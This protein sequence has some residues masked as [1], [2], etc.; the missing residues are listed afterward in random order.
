MVWTLNIHTTEQNVHKKGLLQSTIQQH[1]SWTLT[2]DVLN[3]D[4]RRKRSAQRGRALTQSCNEFVAEVINY[5]VQLGHGKPRGRGGTLDTGDGDDR[6][7]EKSKP[8]KTPQ[9]FRQN[10]K[11]S[12]DQKLTPKKFILNFST[13]IFRL[14]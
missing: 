6:M 3:N 8:S 7:G 4:F 14:F 13:Q 12:L 2:K 10:P 11:T 1:Y 5:A 9:G